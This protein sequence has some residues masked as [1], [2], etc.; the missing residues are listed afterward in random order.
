MFG[1][2][3]D[4]LWNGHVHGA[5]S[6]VVVAVT[7]RVAHGPIEDEQDR[8]KTV[9]ALWLAPYLCWAE[10]ELRTDHRPLAPKRPR[11]P[12]GARWWRAFLGRPVELAPVPTKREPAL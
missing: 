6:F 1:F 12:A 11:R 10:D 5:C 9:E 2:R 3:D 7:R 4:A 8:R